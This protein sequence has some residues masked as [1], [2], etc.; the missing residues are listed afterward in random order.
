MET[1][2][3]VGFI[4]KYFV[5]TFRNNLSVPFSRFKSLKMGQIGCP[6]TLVHN[7]HSTLREIPE[8]HRSQFRIIYQS[9]TTGTVA[10]SNFL[11]KCTL[12]Q[13][14]ICIRVIANKVVCVL[15]KKKKINRF[16]SIYGTIRNHLT[17]TLLIS[18]IYMELLVKPEMLTSYIY[19]DLRL[20][21][22]KQSL[23]ICC[24]MFQH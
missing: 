24:T 12:T 22:L 21:T 5:P 23:S 14:S 18:Y 16:Q 19:M 10:S 8:E 4:E 1:S 3:S 11:S 17:L 20:A 6:E 15:T 2:A 13:H 9:N 7:Y